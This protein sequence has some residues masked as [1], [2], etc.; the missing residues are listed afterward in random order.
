MNDSVLMSSKGSATGTVFR[1]FTFGFSSGPFLLELGVAAVAKFTQAMFFPWEPRGSQRDQTL[2]R[3]ASS[4]KCDHKGRKWERLNTETLPCPTILARIVD[5]WW[6]VPS[7]P[8][9]Q[10]LQTDKRHGQHSHSIAHLL[11]L[12]SQFFRN[13]TA[14]THSNGFC[15]A[16]VVGANSMRPEFFASFAEESCYFF[17][18][19]LNHTWSAPNSHVPTSPIG[20]L[21]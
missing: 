18:S 20:T 12:V 8:F 3:T 4:A 5:H 9:G 10:N 16:L 21:H 1:S 17:I 13:N 19:G 15:F 2:D 14:V 7:K 11:A 6:S